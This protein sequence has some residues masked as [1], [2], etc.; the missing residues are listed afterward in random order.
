MNGTIKAGVALITISLAI[1]A[2]DL[3]TRRA[4]IE[5]LGD[6]LVYQVELGERVHYL[7][8]SFHLLRESDYPL[9]KP[10]EDAYSACEEIVFELGDSSGGGREGVADRFYSAGK[11]AAGQTLKDELG[12]EDHTRLVTIAG[13]LGL[14]ESAFDGYRPWLA[15]LTVATARYLSLGARP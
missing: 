11:Y 3:V 1:A 7:A 2:W 9:P 5:G 4:P 6:G 12:E 10:Y 8:G 13:E 14:D 15:A